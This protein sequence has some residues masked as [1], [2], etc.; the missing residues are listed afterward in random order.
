MKLVVDMKGTSVYT[1]GMENKN[2][3]ERTFIKH[4]KLWKDRVKVVAE[5]YGIN[6]SEAIRFGIDKLYEELI[7]RVEDT[8]RDNLSRLKIILNESDDE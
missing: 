2:Y 1:R 8:D 3:T 7:Q 5:Y 6:L 4:S